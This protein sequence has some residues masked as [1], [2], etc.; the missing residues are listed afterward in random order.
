MCVCVCIYILQKMSI[1]SV[2]THC[3]FYVEQITFP[4]HLQSA[5]M[6]NAVFLSHFEGAWI[7]YTVLMAYVHTVV[8]T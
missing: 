2:K 8:M 7:H 4:S 6:A 3:A 1:K 5:A